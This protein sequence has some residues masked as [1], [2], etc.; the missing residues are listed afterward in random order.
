LVIGGE[1]TVGQVA[2]VRKSERGVALVLSVGAVGI[3]L[4]TLGLSL[5]REPLL[6]LWPLL[7]DSFYSLSVARHVAAGDGITADGTHPTNGFQPLHTFL[8]VPLFALA[9]GERELCLRLVFLLEWVI[10]VATGVGVGLVA[11]GVFA[12]AEAG[13]RRLTAWSAAV[14][15]LAN[16]LALRSHF[17]GLETGLLLCIYVYVW[18]FCQTH[19]LGRPR[20]RVALGVLLGLLVLT[21]IDSAYFV[22]CLFAMEIVRSR[23]LW[24][25]SLQVG[26][27]AA[28]SSPWWLYNLQL[29]GTL[30]PSSGSAQQAWGL[31]WQRVEIG[32]LALLRLLAP[33][34]ADV[35]PGRLDRHMPGHLVAACLLLLVAGWLWRS[36]ARLRAETSAPGGE[37]RLGPGLVLLASVAIL[38]AWYLASSFAVWFYLRYFSPLLLVSAILLGRCAADLLRA[39]PVWAGLGLIALCATVPALAVS[40][41]FRAVDKGNIMYTH[42]LRMVMENVPPGDRVAALQ[43]GTLGFF[44]DGV[45]NLDGK[46]NADALAYRQDI[47]SYLDRENVRWICDWPGLLRS[48]FGGRPEQHGWEVLL[49]EEQGKFVL[50]RRRP[51]EPTSEP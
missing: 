13:I 48:Y 7:E 18:R 3:L 16:P 31:T 14:L 12:G 2:T 30:M 46:V 9:R 50:Y 8:T 51:P 19:P 38:V 43:S 47:W 27:A 37:S 28:V 40:S 45:V 21:R 32:A 34:W 17:N 1:L 5:R 23:R 33:G 29:S 44:R 39:R 42:Q 22:A 25:P 49:A 11:T 10:F 26:V 35:D 20:D 24:L 41:Q 4:A 15:Y 6:P 36:R